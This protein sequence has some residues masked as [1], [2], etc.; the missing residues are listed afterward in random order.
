MLKPG[1]GHG[2]TISEVMLLGQLCAFDQGPRIRYSIVPYMQPRTN[3][4]KRSRRR[5]KEKKKGGE[6][7]VR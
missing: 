5:K 2:A 6:V 1:S 7:S 4:T 3:T